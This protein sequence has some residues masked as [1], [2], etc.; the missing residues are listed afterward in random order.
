MPVFQ[1]NIS[2]IAIS[3]SYDIP[4]KITSFS[5]ANKTGGS[6]TV[7]VAIVVGS[8][9]RNILYNYS[10]AAGQSYVYSG[11]PILFLPATVIGVTTSGS[12][13]YYFTID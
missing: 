4:A 3:S 11:E 1:G 12:C 8:V 7:S 6:V 13:D 5:I 10:I 2:G 9:N